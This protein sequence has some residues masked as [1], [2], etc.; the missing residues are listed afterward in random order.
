[1]RNKKA[2][3]EMSI[4]TVVI[5]VIAVIMLILGLVFVRTIM[6]RG[7]NMVTTTLDGAQAEINKLFGAGAAKEIACMGS[8]NQQLTIVPGRYNVVG[9]GFSPDVP[10][11]YNY[12]FQLESAIIFGTTQDIKTQAQGWIAEKLS[13]TISAAPGDTSY[14]TF[15]IQPPKDAPHTILKFKVRVNNVDRDSIRFEVKPVGWLQQSV[16]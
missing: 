10:K 6:C 16:C 12:Q 11:T 13:G 1:M 3:F 4:T 15:G 2:A 8:G 9:C 14:A 5:L 7:L